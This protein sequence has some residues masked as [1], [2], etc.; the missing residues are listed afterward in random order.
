MGMGT[1]VVR[2]LQRQLAPDKVG[3]GIDEPTFLQGLPRQQIE[4]MVQL[5]SETS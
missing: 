3:P 4:A 1:T 2:N 5:Q